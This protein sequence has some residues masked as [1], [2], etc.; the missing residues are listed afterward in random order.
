M[1]ALIDVVGRAPFI[2]ALASASADPA[3]VAE[4]GAY[5]AR[6]L[7]PETRGPVDIAIAAVE[8]RVKVRQDRLPDI[9]RWLAART[10]EGSATEATR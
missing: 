3:T 4:L 1:E 10:G 9:T 5:A 2:P 7:T 6:Q 8:D